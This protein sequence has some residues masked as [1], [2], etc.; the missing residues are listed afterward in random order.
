MINLCRVAALA[1]DAV[2]ITAPR[3][4]A[5]RR[6]AP[7]YPRSR[8]RRRRRRRRSRPQASAAADFHLQQPE[9]GEGRGL[10]SSAARTRAS[11]RNKRSRTRGSAHSPAPPPPSCAA[12]SRCA[13]TSHRRAFGKPLAPVENRRAARRAGATPSE[14]RAQQDRR[15]WSIAGAIAGNVDIRMASGSLN[16]GDI[17]QRQGVRA[18]SAYWF[19]LP[20]CA[21][22]TLGRIASAA[23]TNRA[24]F[25]V[26]KANPK[27]SRGSTSNSGVAFALFFLAETLRPGEFA[28]DADGRILPRRVGVRRA[29]AG[30]S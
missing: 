4:S 11:S 7:P 10:S 18:M 27:S 19:I 26:R 6:A 22:A 24:P 2:A 25:D 12:A 16:M 13:C 23:E 21:L 20:L 17:G 9:R 3:T 8:C 15:R 28:G 29:R 1:D 5:A 30:P 14:L